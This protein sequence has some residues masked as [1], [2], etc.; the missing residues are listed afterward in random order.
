MSYEDDI[1]DLNRVLFYTKSVEDRA[2]LTHYHL[3][4]LAAVTDADKTIRRLIREVAELRLEKISRE[5]E[6]KEV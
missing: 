3:S 1:N 2:P 4:A 6:N 5:M